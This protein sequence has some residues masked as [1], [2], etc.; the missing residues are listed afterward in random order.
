MA[1]RDELQ[2]N[3]IPGLQTEITRLV[4]L[5]KSQEEEKNRFIASKNETETKNTDVAMQIEAQEKE[6]ARVQVA[7]AESQTL[8]Q[9]NSE[10]QKLEQPPSDFFE[11]M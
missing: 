3:V 11:R 9:E 8:Y 5:K 6:I 1:R 7:I 10:R 2:K 4:E